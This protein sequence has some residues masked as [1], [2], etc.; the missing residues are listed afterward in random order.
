MTALYIIL[1]FVIVFIVFAIIFFLK[2]LIQTRKHRTLTRKEIGKFRNPRLYDETML[3]KARMAPSNSSFIEE[4]DERNDTLSRDLSP[5]ERL[6][7]N[8]AVQYPSDNVIYTEIANQQMATMQ[9]MNSMG[10]NMNAMPP[11]PPMG[12]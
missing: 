5:K 9:D 11:T 3:E 7:Q 2:H 12:F 6:M 8:S 1:D 4:A 10:V